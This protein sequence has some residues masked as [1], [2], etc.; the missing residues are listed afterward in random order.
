MLILLFKNVLKISNFGKSAKTSKNL[1]KPLKN[2][3]KKMSIFFCVGAFTGDEKKSLI[4]IVCFMLIFL[5]L[6]SK[7]R[8]LF[9]GSI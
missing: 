3:E 4:K 1:E 9:L 5:N 2:S 7:A 8:H 6:K